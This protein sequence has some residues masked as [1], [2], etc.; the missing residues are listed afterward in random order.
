MSSPHIEP[1]AAVP[2]ACCPESPR[3]VLTLARTREE[4]ERC[5][6]SREELERLIRRSAAS[7]QPRRV[8]RIPAAGGAL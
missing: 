5:L 7:A 6:I 8:Y 4:Y 1:A 3:G 2:P